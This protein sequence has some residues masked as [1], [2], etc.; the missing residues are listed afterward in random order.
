[1]IIKKFKKIIF[2]LLVLGQLVTPLLA[3]AG[4]ASQQDKILAKGGDLLIH[5]LNTY[6]EKINIKW[7]KGDFRSM[8]SDG[9]A[10]DI[11]ALSIIEENKRQVVFSQYG[12]SKDNDGSTL[13]LGLGYYDLASDHKFQQDIIIGAN[14]FYDAKTGTESLSNPFG[15]GIHK[16]FSVGGT[17]MTAQS[18]AFLNI[19]KGIS[20]TMAGYKASDGYDFGVNILISGWEHI[21]LGATK[22]KYTDENKGSKYTIEYKPNSLFT[23]GAELNNTEGG[24]GSQEN[25]IYME[26]TYKFNT[27]FEDQL[28]PI[29]KVSNNVWDKRYTE[30]ERDNTLRLQLVTREKEISLATLGQ[31]EYQATKE[32]ELS[33]DSF[34]NS[35]LSVIDLKTISGYNDKGQSLTYNADQVSLNE[36]GDTWAAAEVDLALVEKTS[37]NCILSDESV[38]YIKRGTVCNIDVTFEENDEYKA[39]AESIKITT[40][41]KYSNASIGE[42]SSTL[43]LKYVPNRE[44]TNSNS[45]RDYR[46]QFKTKYTTFRINEGYG[47]NPNGQDVFVVPE[48]VGLLAGKW[49]EGYEYPLVWIPK[50]KG[51]NC[52]I[53][54]LYPGMQPKEFRIFVIAG[55]TCYA[56]IIFKENEQFFEKSEIKRFIAEN[57]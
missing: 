30:V 40:D 10:F 42:N 11:K 8:S 49:D 6:G 15:K 12:V 55:T 17:I 4:G 1:M 44:Y 9:I 13:N 5:G 50:Y 45:K 35:T 7:V 33:L 52:I 22:Y 2:N 21:N 3:L 36:D 46:T 29:T 53:A 32:V 56:K 24:I 25:S 57:H 20:E 16:R 54:E 14:I 39:K 19:Y 41:K 48:G 23:F 47:Y 38:V 34:G 43:G 37:K 26:T 51:K 18:G 31:T 27:S 28:K